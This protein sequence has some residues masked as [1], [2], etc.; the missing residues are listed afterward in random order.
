MASRSAFAFSAAAFPS[1]ASFRAVSSS[2]WRFLAVSVTVAH[3]NKDMLV[4][5][6]EEEFFKNK[7][8][9]QLVS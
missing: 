2:D 9:A 3:Y 1:L 6:Y 4:S 8:A 5:I 7:H